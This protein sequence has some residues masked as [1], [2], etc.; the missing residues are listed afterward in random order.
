[1]R[2]PINFIVLSC[3]MVGGL[4]ISGILLYKKRN[5]LGLVNISAH[6]SDDPIL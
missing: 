2:N 4:S 6:N 3:I 1:M 5:P